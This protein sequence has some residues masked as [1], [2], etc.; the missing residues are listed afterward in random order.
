MLAFCATVRWP[1]GIWPTN[2][3]PVLEKVSHWFVFLG[4]GSSGSLRVSCKQILWELDGVGILLLKGW[5]RLNKSDL[6]WLMYIRI[7]I[8]IFIFDLLTPL[9]RLDTLV[10]A[11]CC[12]GR[13]FGCAGRAGPVGRGFGFARRGF[14]RAGRAWLWAWGLA[15]GPLGWDRW[16]QKYKRSPSRMNNLCMEEQQQG[17]KW[18]HLATSCS[19]STL[20]WVHRPTLNIPWNHDGAPAYHRADKDIVMTSMVTYIKVT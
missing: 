16:D 15:G 7:Y 2:A 11:L 12:V 19:T 4:L 14:G 6:Y 10:G 20:L 9:K 13:G 18:I 5:I 3:R 1:K 17:T 8:Y